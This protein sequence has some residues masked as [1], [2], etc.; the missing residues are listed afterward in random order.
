MKSNTRT[1]LVVGA[2]LAALHMT[3]T[4]AQ[5]REP[6]NKNRFFVG[7]RLHFN[8]KADLKTLPGGFNAGPDYD[9]GFVR[10]DISGN[11]GG[12]TWNWGYT[13]TN[14]LFGAS[15]DRQLEL[16]GAPSPRDGITERLEHDLQ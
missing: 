14:Q 6:E 15:P 11:A 2:G 12:K 9:D 10:T 13:S 7:G 5:E 3:A 16:H 8:I 4:R 1:M